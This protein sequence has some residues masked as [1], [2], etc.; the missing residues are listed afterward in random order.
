MTNTSPDSAPDIQHNQQRLIEAAPIPVLWLLGKTASGKSSIIRY[1][2]GAD[3]AEIGNG[4]SPQTRHSQIFDFPDSSAPIVRFL[5][6][7]G[8]G[9]ADY[10][11]EEDLAEFNDRAHLLIVT[12]RVMDQAIESLIK[13]LKRIRQASP[14][15]PVLLVLTCLHDGYPGSQHTEPDP[16]DGDL[17]NLPDSV[18]GTLRSS[19][20]AQL[21][22]FTG[23]CDNIV[24]IDLTSDY[25]GFDNPELGGHRLKRAIIEMLPAAY[26]HSLIQIDQL[27]KT[28]SRGHNDR[29][30]PVILAHSSLAATAAALPMPWVD[31]PLVLGIQS[32]LA[33]KIAKLN[34]QSLD[35]QTIASVTTAMGGRIA[36]RM[37]VRE[38]LKVIPWLGSAVN[39]ATTFAWTF[40]AGWAWNWYFMEINKGHIPTAEEL[41]RV[42]QEQLQRGENFWKATS[43]NSSD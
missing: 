23:L 27:N 38:S 39:A 5:D 4:F 22:R 29:V 43:E 13:P 7:R 37:V 30:A 21:Q 25:E 35:A 20:A 41:R 6:T 14:H 1:L 24:A 33:F 18:P 40:A 15:R 8:L 16:F 17:Q 11:P 36:A 42:Y 2:T 10:D 3:D 12:L 26:R 31:I 32:R 34:N 9:E 28:L 19:I